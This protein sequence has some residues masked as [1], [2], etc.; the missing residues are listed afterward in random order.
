MLTKAIKYPA[1]RGGHDINAK[2][3]A[4]DRTEDAVA[5]FQLAH[6]MREYVERYQEF[7]EFMVSEGFIVA[8]NDHTGHGSSV[9]EMR[10]Y[11]GEKDGWSNMVEDMRSLTKIVASEHPGLPVFLMGHS[12]GS[13]LARIY[14]SRHGSELAGAIF[15]GTASTPGTLSAGLALARLLASR[16][17]KAPAKLVNTLSSIGYND[18]FKPVVTGSEWLTRDEEKVRVFNGNPKAQF[19]FT[20]RGYVDLF[21]MIQQSN[22]KECADK[23]PKSLPILLISGSED[24]VGTYGKGVLLVM[25]QLVDAGCK[26]VEMKLYG[27][28][29]HE[30][31]NELNKDE[32]YSQIAFWLRT[33][34]TLAGTRKKS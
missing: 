7:A 6:G 23:T 3:W 14:V 33:K 25:R 18:K 24:P 27:P 13:F 22:K 34:M 26:D 9:H 4:P 21:E 20:N 17:P 15:S 8:M 31:L 5:I 2:V 11:F 19:I 12:M 1:T 30:M 29:R 10:G 32:V 16:I 28:G